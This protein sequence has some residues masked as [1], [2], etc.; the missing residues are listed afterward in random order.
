MSERWSQL[1][2]CKQSIAWPRKTEQVEAKSQ[3]NLV[4]GENLRFTPTDT[5]RVQSS[6]STSFRCALIYLQSNSISS[7][8]SLSLARCPYYHAL[9]SLS[10]TSECPFVLIHTPSGMPQCTLVP[11]GCVWEREKKKNTWQRLLLHSDCCFF[12]VFFETLL[13][14]HHSGH[15][16]P[17]SAQWQKG[18]RKEATFT[19]GY[20]GIAR[21]LSSPP[22]STLN[23]LMHPVAVINEWMYTRIMHM[24]KRKCKEKNER[25]RKTKW[26]LLICLMKLTAFDQEAVAVTDFITFTSIN[27]VLL[28]QAHLY[29]LSHTHSWV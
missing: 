27:S 12:T 29:S 6:L 13:S 19:W 5:V 7:R 25:R 14:S 17:Q 2:Q 11:Y 24:N 20:N 18:E 9:H 26:P 15:V 23:H 8:I 21:S 10:G 28:I 1:I 3:R 16:F 4:S 22:V